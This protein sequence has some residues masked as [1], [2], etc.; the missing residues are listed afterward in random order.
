MTRFGGFTVVAV[1]L[2]RLAFSAHANLVVDF[3]PDTT[4]VA[5]FAT[6]WTDSVGQSQIIGDH[7]TI[8]TGVTLTGGSLFSDSAIAALG[9]PVDFM[10]YSNPTAAPIIDI[11]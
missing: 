7:F 6:N 2:G 10:I 1:F 4:G 5:V 9:T 8:S 3:S 11:P